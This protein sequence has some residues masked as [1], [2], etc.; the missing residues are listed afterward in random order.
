MTA[1]PHL[2]SEAVIGL[3]IGI[4]GDGSMVFTV[5]DTGIGIDDDQIT[6]NLTPFGQAD[7]SLSRKFDGAGL[8]LPLTRGLVEA[9]RGSLRVDSEKGVGATVAFRLPAERVVGEEAGDDGSPTAHGA[10]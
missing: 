2:A 6:T 10:L 3:D 4:D 7:G 5:S 8:G 9:H 1:N